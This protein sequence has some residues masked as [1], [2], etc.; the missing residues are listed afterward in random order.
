MNGVSVTGHLRAL[1]ADNN[2]ANTSNDSDSWTQNLL[3][4]CP[5]ETSN[6]SNVNVQEIIEAAGQN[7]SNNTEDLRQ[8]VY[9]IIKTHG[10]FEEDDSS[11]QHVSDLLLGILRLDADNIQSQTNLSTDIALKNLVASN[12]SFVI[13]DAYNLNDDCRTRAL[14]FRS[15]AI[16]FAANALS[17]NAIGALY[18]IW[19]VLPQ[20]VSFYD[21]CGN[22]SFTLDLQPFNGVKCNSNING[23][24]QNLGAIE[25]GVALNPSIIAAAIPAVINHCFG[26]QPFNVSLPE[27]I[28]AV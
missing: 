14:S 22:M 10:P 13:P 19:S 3:Q 9:D 11:F 1:Q 16:N 2:T 17:G 24:I 27:G 6:N 26:T 20:A 5:D 25:A 28:T 12:C 18:W 4:V 23:M 15:S 21:I 8:E 7:F